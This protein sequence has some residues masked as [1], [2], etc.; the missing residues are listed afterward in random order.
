MHFRMHSSLKGET[1]LLKPLDKNYVDIVLL[2]TLTNTSVSAFLTYENKRETYVGK[3]Q[4]TK[5]K[6]LKQINIIHGKKSSYIVDI[7]DF[8]QKAL[9]IPPRGRTAVWTC[10]VLL[11]YVSDGHVRITPGGDYTR[12][13]C[14]V[15]V[16]VIY[17]LL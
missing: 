13:C 9:E 10:F 2:W 17:Y 12:M 11:G 7:V 1:R 6:D 14:V 16:M 15:P 4:N 3:T 5:E 8:V